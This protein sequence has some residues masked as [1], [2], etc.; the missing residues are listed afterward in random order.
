MAKARRQVSEKLKLIDV[1]IELLDAR[2]PTSSRNPMIFDIIANKPR[3][4]LL[5]KADLADPQITRQWVSYLEAEGEQVLT[6]DSQSG[7][8]IGQIAPKCK[9]IVQDMLDKR[10][11]KGM[12]QR[13]VRALIVGIPNVGKSSLINR[14]AKKS[15]AKTGDRPGITKAQQWIK[16]GDDFELLD[17]PGILWPK[18]DDQQVGLRLAASGAIKDEILDVAE[19]AFYVIKWM[20]EAY[21]QRLTE[22]F[23][24]ELLDPDPVQ[25][26]EAIGRRRG[27]LMAGGHIDFDK[28]SELILRELRS[29]KLGNISFEQPDKP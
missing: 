17:T 12:A 19:V 26:M 13:A 25:I 24:L 5:N 11:R 20:K 29:G 9:H 3:L 18:F 21:P 28:V 1:V 4:V 15:V 7:K 8:G 6:V 27:C 14:L 22:R 16:A 23:N 2:L 10:V